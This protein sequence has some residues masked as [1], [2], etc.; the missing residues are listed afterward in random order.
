MTTIGV[1]TSEYAGTPDFDQLAHVDFAIVRTS[2]GLDV[3]KAAAVNVAGF[4]AAGVRDVWGYAYLRS[5][6]GG[7]PQADHALD[8]IAGFDGPA[9]FVNLEP[10]MSGKRPEDEPAYARLVAHAFLRRHI[11]RTG[12]RCGVYGPVEYLRA[13]HLDADLVG[14]LWA[15]LTR[16]DGQPHPGPVP[17]LPPW[18]GA[19]IH[20]H[21]HNA[22]VAPSV[23][24]ARVVVDWNRSPHTLPELRSLLGIESA[25]PL[26]F[27]ILGPVVAGTR[28]AEG[29]GATVETFVSRDEG[30][31]IG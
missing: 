14:P 9:L 17:P 20:Q 25:A 22:R 5:W 7:A 6:H 16:K 26:T 15:A 19:A 29:R 24:G 2:T 8:T 10:V 31:V 3:D 21:Q 23:P 1:D 4:R 30:P 27:D 11:E 18:G 13:L 12:R 28:A